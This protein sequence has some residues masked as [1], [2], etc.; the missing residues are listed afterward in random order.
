MMMVVE[1]TS[2]LAERDRYAKRRSCAAAR[3]PIYLLVGRDDKTV[4]LFSGPAR[5]RHINTAAVRSAR[6]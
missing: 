4:T 3:I 2:S 5:D 1:V 6:P